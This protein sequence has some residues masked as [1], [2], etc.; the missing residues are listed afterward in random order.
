MEYLTLISLFS[1]SAF[2]AMSVVLIILKEE[3]PRALIIAM[4]VLMPIVTVCE[5]ALISEVEE[6]KDC[7]AKYKKIEVVFYKKIK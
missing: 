3:M 4:F 6:H 1:I 7:N 2:I 5:A